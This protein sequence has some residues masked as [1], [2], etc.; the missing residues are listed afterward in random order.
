M[1]PSCTL[2]ASARID[3]RS[4]APR[5]WR[6]GGGWTRELL[7]WPDP[8]NWQLRISLATIESAGPFSTFIGVQRR[9]IVIEGAGV[10]LKI[11]DETHRLALDTEPLS[12][13]GGAA[14][15]CSPIDGPTSDLNLM[16]VRGQGEMLRVAPGVAWIS[17]LSQRGLF[18]RVAGS[19]G[20]PSGGHE[21]VPSRTLLWFH[22]AAGVAFSFA[23]ELVDPA[24]PGWWL[25]Y[26]A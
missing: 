19:L 2:P 23:P 15:H 18:A 5:R 22:D 26:A 8:L 11:N 3:A 9:I 14:V 4:V 16:T 12:F 6:N 24:T 1:S 13:D 7:T 21:P 20:I 10:L 25:G 17:P